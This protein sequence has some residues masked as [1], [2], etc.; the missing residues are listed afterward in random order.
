[1]Y[2]WSAYKQHVHSMRRYGCDVGLPILPRA[3]MSV[4]DAFRFLLLRGLMTS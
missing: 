4:Q 2:K 3:H 1:M